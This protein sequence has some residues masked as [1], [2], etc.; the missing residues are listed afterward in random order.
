MEKSERPAIPVVFE[1]EIALKVSIDELEKLLDWMACIFEDY[2]CPGKIC[3]QLAV[4]TEEIFVNIARYAY[5]TKDGNALIRVGRA[6]SALV[7]Q[8][9]DTG[10]HFNP[11]EKIDPDIGA[12]IENRSI[13]GLGI[14]ITK[15]WMD[16]IQYDRV[17]DENRLTLYK[18]I[19]AQT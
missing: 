1:R 10:K 7:M 12:P 14:Y 4:I 6:G 13:G 17:N 2:S 9:V 8:F 18:S 19:A 16:S 15:K 11:L 3:N 5:D